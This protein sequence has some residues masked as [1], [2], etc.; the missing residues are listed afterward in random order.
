MTTI[1]VK[2]QAVA[3]PSKATISVTTQPVQGPI[4]IDGVQRGVGS[5]NW[6]VDVGATVKVSFG[7]VAGYAAPPDQTVTATA[8]TTYMVTGTYTVLSTV[9]QA[10]ITISAVDENNRVLSSAQIFVDDVLKG[11]GTVTV[12][13]LTY[14]THTISFGSVAGYVTPKPQT[15]LNYGDDLT[16]SGKYVPVGVSTYRV[17]VFVDYYSVMLGRTIPLEGET[18]KAYQG[19]VLVTSAITGSEGVAILVLPAGTYKVSCT[20]LSYGTQS[21]T[22]TVPPDASVELRYVGSGLS[23]IPIGG[24]GVESTLLVL[25]IAIALLLIALLWRPRRGQLRRRR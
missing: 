16:F 18:V 15:F 25:A 22:V 13:G 7:V 3:S 21:A 23:I 5:V 20:T 12:S 24:V 19:D 1:M 11:T 6:Q 9:T 14:G 17:T 2:Y 10:K 8:A 4:L